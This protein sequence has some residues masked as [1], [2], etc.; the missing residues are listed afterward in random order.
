[1]STCLCQTKPEP[2]QI[3]ATSCM[4]L[5]IKSHKQDYYLWSLCQKTSRKMRYGAPTL[6]RSNNTG[7]DF[8][9]LRSILQ[10]RCPITTSKT[11]N[12]LLHGITVDLDSFRASGPRPVSSP[13]FC[14]PQKNI[15]DSFHLLS[16]SFHHFSSFTTF[17]RNKNV[18]HGFLLIGCHPKTEIAHASVLQIRQGQMLQSPMQL[19]KPEGSLGAVPTGRDQ[20][21]A[22]TWHHLPFFRGSNAPQSSLWLRRGQS[23]RTPTISLRTEAR[24]HIAYRNNQITALPKFE[25]FESTKHI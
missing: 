7:L 2:P 23:P 11:V 8:P 13:P 5:K 18:W 6:I 4:W 24:A 16:Q 17:C 22:A 21:N 12:F 1:M 14:G 10:S 25:T 19:S 20:C 15:V 9:R 3:P